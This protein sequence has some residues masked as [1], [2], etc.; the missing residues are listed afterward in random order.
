MMAGLACGEPNSLAWPVLRDHTDGAIR[1]R[2][3]VAAAGMR[4]LA[5]PLAGDT[6]V[7]AGDSAAAG[8]GIILAAL[9]D[10]SGAALRDGLALGPDS[11]IL[12]VSTEGNTDPENYQRVIAGGHEL[13]HWE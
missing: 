4:A 7:E 11:H 10:T 12:I 3:S 1:V 2:D 5:H 9:R 6:A 13:A 8:L